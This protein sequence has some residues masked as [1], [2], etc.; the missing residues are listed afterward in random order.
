[1]P[2]RLADECCHGYDRDGK[3][4]GMYKAVLKLRRAGYK[5]YRMPRQQHEVDGKFVTTRE[6]M[7]LAGAAR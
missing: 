1:M 3:P 5:V 7:A 4:V 6:L 2:D